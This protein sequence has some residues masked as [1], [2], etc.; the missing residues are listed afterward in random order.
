MKV[1]T[2]IVGSGVAATVIAEALLAKKADASILIIE[3]GT[4][5]KT[6]DFG[7]WEN[8]LVTGAL[9]Y[10]GA[11]DGNYPQRDDPGENEHAGTTEVPLRGARL[12]AYGGS[13]LHWGG[14]SFRLKPEDFYLKT[15][16]GEALDWPF[17]YE[18]LEPYY[19][20]A[21]AH[22]AVSGDSEDLVETRS[23]AFP[24][25]AFPFTLEDKLYADAFSKLSIGYGHLPIARRG[26]SDVP[27]RHAPCQTTGTCK[28]CPFGARYVASN[29]LDD[30]RDWNDYPNLRIKLGAPVLRIEMDGKRKAKGVLYYDKARGE[31]VT[32]EADQVI[33]AAGAIESAKLLLRSCPDDWPDG[34]GNDHRQVGRYL[35]T[36][37]YFT[38]TAILPKNDRNLQPE[39][40]FPTLVSRHFDSPE[41][42]AL[43][44]YM[45]VAPPDTVA[46]GQSGLNPTIAGM[47]QA[48]QNRARIDAALGGKNKITIQGMLEVFGR[49]TNTVRNMGTLNKFGLPMTSVSYAQDTGFDARILTIE[50]K[51]GEIFGAMGAKPEGARSVSWR[52][53]HAAS[54]CRMSKSAATGV[55]DSDLKVHGTDNL[56]VISNAVFP[57]L[58]AVNPTLTLTALA[59]RLGDHLA[60]MA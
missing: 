6:K 35:I 25:K 30:L 14:W 47:M 53:D 19:C 33:I 8:F 15:N 34:V 2:V 54:L 27:S 31:A 46:L 44:K 21:E 38:M 29:Y 49:E 40:N 5:V 24:F 58:G 52:A 1:G 60:G 9:P 50:K 57:N 55:V 10:D 28:Y 45:M 32:V 42:Q 39:L 12:F 51:I 37:P 16:T 3:A 59:I 7:L 18:A 56:F 48:G 43:G 23:S 4:Q 41:E 13:T 17:D 22:L 11:R 36:H 26:L 20:R